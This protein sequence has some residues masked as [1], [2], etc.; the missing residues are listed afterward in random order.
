MLGRLLFQQACP[1]KLHI[2]SIDK[3]AWVQAS[4]ED[5]QLSRAWQVLLGRPLFE[6]VSSSI[7]YV[8]QM[9]TRSCAQAAAGGRAAEPAMAGAAGQAAV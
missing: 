6:Q 8:D 7:P 4:E 9:F 3:Q 5:L 2:R 1:G